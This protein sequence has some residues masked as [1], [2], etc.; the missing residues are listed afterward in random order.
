MGLE[1]F[2]AL[3]GLGPKKAMPKPAASP[4]GA[5]S[6]AR[7]PGAGTPTPEDKA[8]EKAR[9]KVRAQRTKTKVDLWKRFEPLH[10]SISGTMSSFYKA[11]EKATGKVVGLKVLDPKKCAP[12]ESRYKGLNKPPEGEIGEQILGPNIVKTIEWGVSNE[13]AAFVVEEFLDGALL[14]ALLS[15]KEPLPPA[16]RLDLVRQ[17]AGALECVH[18]AGFVHRDICPRNFILCPDGR[19]V[20][21]DFGLTV[22]EKPVFLQPGNRIGTPNYMAPEVVRRRQADKRIDIF[23]LGVTAYEICTLTLPW[24]RGTTGRTAL[25]HDTI[26]PED[27]RVHWPDIPPAL[28]GAIMACI[29]GDA[30]KRPPSCDDFLARIA[31]VTID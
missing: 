17:A 6:A 1:G 12:I 4:K 27:I 9:L 22:P 18:R 26:Q 31:K 29:A 2:L 16:Q 30:D 7:R 8:A 28:A 20:L 15:K 19:L 10:S 5:P 3:F 23:S 25:A 14:H 24:P 13:D 11:R 21:F